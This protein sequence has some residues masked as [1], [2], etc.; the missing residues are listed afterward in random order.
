MEFSEKIKKLKA[1][2]GL[3]QENLAEMLEVPKRTIE[4]WESGNR[5]PPGYVQRLIIKEIK[6]KRPE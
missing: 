2:R 5:K 4:S 6:R 1:S 3:T